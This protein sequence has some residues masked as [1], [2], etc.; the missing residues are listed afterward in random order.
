MPKN[1]SVLSDSNQLVLKLGRS[2]VEISLESDSAAASDEEDEEGTEEV[3]ESESSKED[4]GAN[5]SV[6][7]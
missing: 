7:G 1:V 3:P 5:K 6:A 2:R 4:A